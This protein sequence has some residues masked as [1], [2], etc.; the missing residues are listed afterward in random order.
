M[1][2]VLDTSVLVASL[3]SFTGASTLLVDSVLSGRLR[4]L[5]SVP[6]VL[7]YEAVLTRPEHLRVS[8]FTELEAVK[9]VKAFCKMGEPVHLSHRLRP[10]MVDPNDEF[11]L[12]T[13]FHGKAEAIVTFNYK[14]FKVAAMRFGIQTISPQEAW[15]KMR[16]I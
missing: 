4:P 12:E 3:R 9:I 13:A 16:S 7:E 1:R 14:D 5:V 10:Q 2:V 8:G 6:L 11:V 15:E